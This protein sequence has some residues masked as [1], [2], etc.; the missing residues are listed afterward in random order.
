MNVFGLKTRQGFLTSN[1]SEKNS[2]RGRVIEQAIEFLS[3]SRTLPDD[4]LIPWLMT[5]HGVEGLIVDL[6]RVREENSLERAER[7]KARNR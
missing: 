7:E 6:E 2:E 5:T 3:K 4:E 1:L